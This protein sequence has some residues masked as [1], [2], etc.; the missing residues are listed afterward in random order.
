M[1]IGCNATSA[2]CESLSQLPPFCLSC[3]LYL[4]FFS[5]PLFL[6]SSFPI[7]FS[8]RDE[9]DRYYGNLAFRQPHRPRRTTD[10]PVSR[11]K[12]GPYSNN[13]R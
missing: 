10:S 11:A 4:F 6:F 8:A 13:Q 9:G 12:P 3:C 1:C 7:L 5:P 2:N